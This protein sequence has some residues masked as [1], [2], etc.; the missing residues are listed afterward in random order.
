MNRTRL[1]AMFILGAVLAAGS[2]GCVERRLTIGSAPEGALVYLND[3][4]IGRTPIT[5]P[6]TWDG[7]YDIRF[8]YEKDVGTPE[9]PKIEHYYLHTHQKTEVPWFSIPPLDLFAELWPAQFKDEQVWAFA[10]PQVPEEPA[11]AVIKRAEKLKAEL[12]ASTR[13]AAK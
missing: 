2:A 8:R 3:K 6:I 4:E 13:P 1:I 10:V 11:D 5:V 9:K 7:D 12:E